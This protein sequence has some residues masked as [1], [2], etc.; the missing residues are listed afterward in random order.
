MVIKSTKTIG[1]IALAAILV[2]AI[3]AL[4]SASA[5]LTALDKIGMIINIITS[6]KNT[7]S[8]ILTEVT[9]I[10]GKLDGTVESL[11]T[12]INRNV[13]AINATVNSPVFGNEEIKNEV[14][15]IESEVTDSQYVPF[16]K[17]SIPNGICVANS[18]TVFPGRSVLI[19][20]DS[21]GTSGSF[22]V[23]SIILEVSGIDEATDTIAVG[24]LTVDN[25]NTIS[26]NSPDVTGSGVPVQNFVTFDALGL[27]VASG[28]FDF[29]FPSSLTA[30]SAGSTDMFLQLGCRNGSPGSINGRD[31]E[32]EKVQVSGWKQPDE[33]IN[34]SFVG[35]DTP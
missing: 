9:N 10:E 31:I 21:T 17:D 27:P 22:R 12:N 6:I 1:G 29:S 28:S 35:F 24:S 20:I 23:D 4:P 33:T 19:R 30:E 16:R 15:N 13:T 34:I 8:D 2:V 18:N 25:V 11:V 32:L 26:H 5:D 3:F 7:V 14:I